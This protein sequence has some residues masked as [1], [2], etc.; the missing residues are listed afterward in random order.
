MPAGKQAPAKIIEEL[1]EGF[2]KV[3]HFRSDMPRL[4]A[5]KTRKGEKCRRK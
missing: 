4:I 2:P 5:M 1:S 3:S